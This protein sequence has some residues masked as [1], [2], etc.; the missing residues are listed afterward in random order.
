MNFHSVAF[1]R[2]GR[3]GLVCQVSSGRFG[4]VDLFLGLACLTMF[5][6]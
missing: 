5:S 6:F 2:F 3:V 1:E 4:L